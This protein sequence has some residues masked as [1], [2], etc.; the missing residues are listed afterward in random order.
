MVFGGVYD[1]WAPGG[2]DLRRIQEPS[3]SAQTIGGYILASPF[4]GDGWIVRVDSF[5]DIVG[6]HFV[7]AI[8]CIFGGIWHISTGPWGWTRRAFVWSGKAYLSNSL[9]ALSVMGLTA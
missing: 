1:P 8:G 3:T 6:G 7:V 2:G 5:E 4:G 9:A